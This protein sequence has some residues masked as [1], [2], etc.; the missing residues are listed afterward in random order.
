MDGKGLRPLI[1]KKVGEFLFPYG[2]FPDEDFTQVEGYHTEYFTSPTGDR[3]G[4]RYRTVLLV[5]AE[6]IAPI[7]LELCELLPD[8]VRVVLE[9]ASEDV[10]T[11]RDVFVSEIDVASEEFVGVYATDAV[12]PGNLRRLGAV[13]C[14]HR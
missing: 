9:R 7:F 3:I 12:S 10:Y 1:R 8:T 11:D 4:D 6:K 2:T 5:S 13:R 14:S